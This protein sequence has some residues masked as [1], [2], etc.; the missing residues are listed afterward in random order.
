M[1]LRK[2]AIGDI[3]LKEQ[4]CAYLINIFKM[5]SVAVIKDYIILYFIIIIL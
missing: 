1:F 4:Q 2:L 5:T 3:K